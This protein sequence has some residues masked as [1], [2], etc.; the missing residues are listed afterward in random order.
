MILKQDHLV[1]LNMNL[2]KV[3]EMIIDTDKVFLR[4][5]EQIANLS[6]HQVV[7][8]GAILVIPG[9]PIVCSTGFNVEGVIHAEH[10]VIESLNG[11]LFDTEKGNLPKM[12]LYVT[13]PPCEAC[14]NII[15]RQGNINRVVWKAGSPDFMEKWKFSHNRAL[16]KL[17]HRMIEVCEV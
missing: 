6:T 13:H 2:K 15:I 16:Q 9:V 14:A 12:T 4:V 5:A 1:L 7:T 8:V 10:M 11:V 17:N 3:I